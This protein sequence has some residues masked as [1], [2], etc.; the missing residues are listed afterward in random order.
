VRG[1]FNNPAGVAAVL[2]A[3]DITRNPQFDQQLGTTVTSAAAILDEQRQADF[4]GVQSPAGDPNRI[5]L[6]MFRFTAQSG[7]TVT[8]TADSP[9]LTGGTLLNDG[10]DISGRINPINATVTVAPVPEPAGLA[11]AGLAA[12]GWAAYRRRRAPRAAVPGGPQPR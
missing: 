9:V 10:T 11:L 6:G 4:A 7:G 3:N 12:L 8:L 2:S 5:F 1:S